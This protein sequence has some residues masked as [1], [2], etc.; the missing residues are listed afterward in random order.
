M[1]NLTT[2]LDN[3][4]LKKFSAFKDQIHSQFFMVAV[5]VMCWT[6]WLARNELIFNGNQVSI[7]DCRRVFL[8]EVRLV[9][10]RVK[11]SLSILFDQWTQS[12][13]TI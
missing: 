5:I 6:I 13:G 2:S 11:T 3:G 10:L 4:I 7:Q 1:L 12:L 8:K 9:S